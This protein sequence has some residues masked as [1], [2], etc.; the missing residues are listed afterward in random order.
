MFTGGL[1]KSFIDT[2]G[3]EDLDTKKS[4]LGFGLT[5]PLSKILTSSIW[6]SLDQFC[7]FSTFSTF[8]SDGLH[9]LFLN[10]SEPKLDLTLALNW[11]DE[12]D[13]LFST[14]KILGDVDD[15]KDLGSTLLGFDISEINR[16]DSIEELITEE[17]NDGPWV[18]TLGQN[19]KKDLL[20]DEEES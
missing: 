8:L 12:S 6:G 3:P 7:V 11:L 1:G 17:L 19:D 10:R 5:D 20:R 13:G 18:G 14:T 4:N 16:V 9:H 2:S 15:L